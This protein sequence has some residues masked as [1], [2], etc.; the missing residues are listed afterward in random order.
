MNE[1]FKL[2]DINQ[3][4]LINKQ[5]LKL[6]CRK[7]GLNPND[8]E[9]DTLFNSFKE[10]VGSNALTKEEFYDLINY[11]YRND[12][13]QPA[14]ML[15]TLKDEIDIL[16]FNKSGYLTKDQIRNLY[17]RMDLQISEAE[18]EGFIEEIGDKDL[19][20]VEEDTFV[21]FIIGKTEK[22][23]NP[24]VGRAVVK[25]RG[26]YSPGL[27]DL[28]NSFNNM[29][30]NY[31]RSFTEDLY[32]E[33]EHRPCSQIEPKLSSSKLYYTNIFPRIKSGALK[34]KGKTPAISEVRQRPLTTRAIST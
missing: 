21:S 18:L 31:F 1:V 26:A 3:N 20:K 34:F 4:E 27:A 33:G 10:N 6:G 12:L 25:L 5:E 8:D 28:I 9:I 30:E 16:D 15:E 14:M 32:L 13:V 23:K 17:G 24:F 7:L 2:I 29:P 19:E 22:F 11:K